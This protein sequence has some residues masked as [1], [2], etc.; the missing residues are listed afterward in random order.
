DEGQ[1]AYLAGYA[2]PARYTAMAAAGKIPA[3]LA[4]LLPPASDYSGVQF[5]TV[6]QITKASAIVVANWDSMVGG[7]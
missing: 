3:S 7:S 5:A 4:A 6:D 1:L 2:H